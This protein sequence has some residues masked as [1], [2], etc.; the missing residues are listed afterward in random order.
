M[1][2]KNSQKDWSEYY[3]ITAN[4]PPSKLLVKALGFVKNKNKAIDIGGGALKDTRYLLGQGFDVTVID[5]SDLMADE[6]QKISS[7]KLHYFVSDFDKFNFPESKFDI[8]LS[9]FALPFNPPET[10][11]I[12]F[13]RIKKSIVSGGIF[14]GQLFGIKDQWSKKSDMVFFTEKQARNLFSGMEIIEFVEE[15]GDGT[16]ANGLP[17]YWHIFHFI[18]R[19]I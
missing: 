17:K 5:K 16:T 1:K 3:K 10:F 9:I 19:K 8:A 2:T 4:K 6:A 11:D 18:A 14:C 12:V 13:E 15:Q 7:N